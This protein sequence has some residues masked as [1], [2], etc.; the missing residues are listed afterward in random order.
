M[1]KKQAGIVLGMENW[2][3]IKQAIN[4]V[5]HFKRL[6]EKN[7]NEFCRCK[8]IQHSKKEGSL[9]RERRPM[10]TDGKKILC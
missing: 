9:P 2:F 5:C 10:K 3:N 4:V 1:K 8:N 7:D 6:K